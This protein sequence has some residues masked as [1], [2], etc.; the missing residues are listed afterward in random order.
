MFKLPTKLAASNCPARDCRVPIGAIHLPEC[1]VATCLHTGQQRILHQEELVDHDCGQDTWT[2]LI[3]G[4]AECHEYGWFVRR[5]TSTDPADAT[6][7]PCTIDTPGA[8]ADLDRLVRHCTWNPERRRWD[9][10]EEVPGRG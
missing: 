5:A 9:R 6:W 7:V 3:Y 4:V 2:G 10:R 1:E 8:V